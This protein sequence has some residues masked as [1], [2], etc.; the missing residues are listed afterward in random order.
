MRVT[1]P[2]DRRRLIEA[3][4]CAALVSFCGDARAEEVT[5]HSGTEA[6]PVHS[7]DAVTALPTTQPPLFPPAFSGPIKPLLVPDPEGLRQW[8]ESLQQ[9]VLVQG[10]GPDLVEDPAISES[11]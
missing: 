9:G 11:P 10:D 5:I 1:C 4:V 7:V 6:A 8:K 3:L 2:G